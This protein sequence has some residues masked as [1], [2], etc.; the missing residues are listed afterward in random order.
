M[1]DVVKVVGVRA[2]IFKKK[3]FLSRPSSM[4]IYDNKMHANQK[5]DI[6]LNDPKES[7][8]ILGDKN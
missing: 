6:G 3:G 7:I 1:I 2:L 5:G 8:K 4:N